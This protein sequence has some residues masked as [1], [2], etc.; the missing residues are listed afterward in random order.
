MDICIDFHTALGF[1]TIKF[2]IFVSQFVALQCC[3]HDDI[4]ILLRLV[5]GGHRGIDGSSDGFSETQVG[6]TQGP[7]EFVF[8]PVSARGFALF[9]QQDTSQLR[10]GLDF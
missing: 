2:N 10:K 7:L 5:F 1:T 4:A 8:M 9:R 6:R 3:Y